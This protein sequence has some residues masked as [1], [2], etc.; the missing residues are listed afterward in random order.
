MSLN[1]NIDDEMTKH[2]AITG[3]NVASKDKSTFYSFIKSVASFTGDLSQLTCPGFLLCGTSII[4]YCA[5]Y[6]DH[7]ALIKNIALAQDPLERTQAVTAW[8]LSSLY[9]SFRSR[10]KDNFEKKPY[11]PILGEKFI[12]S[13]KD[14]SGDKIDVNCEQVSHH[15]PISAFHLE[16]QEHGIS[17][18]GH[19][20]TYLF[21]RNNLLT[22]FVLAG[23]KSKFKG[24]TIKVT[25]VG[26]ITVNL[27]NSDETFIISLPE[28]HIRS[29]I[30]GRPFLDLYH[31]SYVYS[32]SGYIATIKYVQ[33][34]WFSG[35]YFDISGHIKDSQGNVHRTIAGKWT[36][37]FS[38]SNKNGDKLF[39]FNPE[40]T[41]M[42][43]RIIAPL[44][45]QE[46]NE[47]QR[48]WNEVSKAI[49]EEEYA[50]ATEKK[51]AIE[52]KQ[53]ALRKQRQEENITWEP[54]YFSFVKDEPERI[55]IEKAL[56]TGLEGIDEGS[57]VFKK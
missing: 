10:N 35:D 17:I 47:S 7:P 12:C 2:E 24:T 30:T 40:T 50:L 41:P 18:N 3:E 56:G 51:S 21:L 37:E 8:F 43:E 53:R 39:A 22:L 42:A 38:F 54:K 25:Q 28:M 46:E 26:H 14:A 48:L 32:S 13:L 15:P 4:E 6:A 11:N 5:H 16:S 23:Q 52:N 31:E 44:E 9:G 55:K 20:M 19:S 1:N 29:L 34:G 33:K 27:K 57:W 45:Q 49:E 36:E